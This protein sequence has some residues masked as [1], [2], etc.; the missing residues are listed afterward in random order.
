MVKL[1]VS[2]IDQQPGSL[3]HLSYWVQIVSYYPVVQV[4]LAGKSGIGA[5]NRLAV[6][7]QAFTM[8][9]ANHHNLCFGKFGS[10]VC[11]D[12]FPEH[13]DGLLVSKGFYFLFDGL[14]VVYLNFTL[15]RFWDIEVL[16]FRWI[17]L[18]CLSGA[19]P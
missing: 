15:Y 12:N 6:F 5:K 2:P 14:Q 19:I 9:R 7:C 4:N 8:N 13:G 1:L 18:I 3:V 17:F 11:H 16:P 10:I